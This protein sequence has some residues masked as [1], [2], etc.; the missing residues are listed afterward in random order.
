MQCATGFRVFI[1]FC[2]S[3]AMPAL[4]S[5]HSDNDRYAID[6]YNVVWETPSADSGESMPVG[7]HSIGLNVWVEDGDVMFYAARSGAFS[8]HNEYLKLGRFRLQLTPNA[9][10]DGEHFRQELKLREGY[11]EITGRK[12]GVTTRVDIWVEAER[13]VIHVDVESTSPVDATIRYENWRHEDFELLDHQPGE[14]GYSRRFSTFGLM[15]YPGEV[16]R[17]AD[18]I[19][20]DGDSVLFYHRNRD[21]QLLLDKYIALQG[22]DAVGEELTNPQRSLTFGGRLYAEGFVAD[23]AMTGRYL[24]APYG[25]WSLRS[26]QP[27]AS[28]SITIDTHI[29]RTIDVEQWEAG[30]GRL[31]ANDQPAAQDARTATLRWWHAFWDRSWLMINPGAENAGAPSWQVARN[32]QLFRY[33]LGTNFYG[34]APTKFN[35]GNFTFDPSLVLPRGEPTFKRFNLGPTPDYR[36]WGGGSFTAQN[37]RL[38]YWPMLKTGDFAGMQP[39]FDFYRDALPNAEARVRAYWGHGGAAFTEQ[40]ENFGLPIMA[41]W[42]FPQAEAQCRNRSP[43]TERGVQWHPA[44]ALL[45]Q[46]QLEFS[47]MILEYHRYSGAD[48]GRWMPFIK[49]SLRFYDEHYQYR[50]KQREGR[51]LDENGK[52][53]I[54]PSAGAERIKRA[55]NSAD[56]VA[57]LRAT[58]HALL[59]LPETY[60]AADER[61]YFSGLLDRVPE[62]RFETENGRKVMR[63][64]DAWEEDSGANE[65]PQFYALFPYNLYGLERDDMAAFQNTWDDDGL[66]GPGSEFA[67]SKIWS[68]KQDGIFM[69]RLGRTEDARKYTLAKLGNSTQRFPTFWGPGYDWTPDHNWG[70]TGMIGL[71][72]M[73]MQ[74]IGDQILLFPAWPKDWDVDFKLHAPH[75]T[76][77]QGRLVDGDLVDLQVTPVSRRDDV[78]VLQPR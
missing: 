9:F 16:I 43:E 70:G 52:L 30:L 45:Y 5:A 12:G 38:V 3:L 67:G 72:E 1:A 20:H 11:V 46:A 53:V 40:M 55:T 37:Q 21:D 13:P 33:Q 2:L 23:E 28:H 74:T 76:I 6:Q 14:E 18:T 34:D 39:Q 49:S 7:G 19:A 47:Y 66:W 59:A 29:A 22:L 50:L 69:A 27:S 78:V 75:E 56:A 65:F 15:C 48:I 77:V 32:Y 25:G 73:L 10:D 24:K 36:S 44:V 51:A 60:L 31:A 61:R 42:G 58:L 26:A 64:A 68:W 63:M 35:G 71:Q 54:Y 62:L 41:T 4:A 8:E 57:G 17:Y